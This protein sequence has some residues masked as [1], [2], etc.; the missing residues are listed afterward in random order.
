MNGGQINRGE[1]FDHPSKKNYQ[2]YLNVTFLVNDRAAITGIVC[3]DIA[4]QSYVKSHGGS[5]RILFHP[6]ESPTARSAD[7]I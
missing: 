7:P 5:H 4:I 2:F 6:I 3:W 1:G